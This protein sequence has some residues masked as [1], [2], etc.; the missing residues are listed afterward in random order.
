MI[1]Q[2]SLNLLDDKVLEGMSEIGGA[3]F[4]R[5]PVEQVVYNADIEII[6]LRSDDCA[7]LLRL[8]E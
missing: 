1:V 4:Q 7:A 2:I 3:G 6:E 5:G 8:G